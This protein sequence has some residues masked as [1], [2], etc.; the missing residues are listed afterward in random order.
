MEKFVSNK[1]P[2]CLTSISVSPT[3]VFEVLSHLNV[4]KVCGPDGICPHLLKE[5]A[6]ELSTS[7]SFMFNKSLQDGVLPI[8]WTSANI[9]PI[10]KKGDKHLVNNYR[11]ISLTSIVCKVLE[12]LIHRSLYP[13]LESHVLQSFSVWFSS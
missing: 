8:D 10:F 5:G 3:D 6:Q 2:S 12:K 4:N 7:L 11:P 1:L 9:T 13:L